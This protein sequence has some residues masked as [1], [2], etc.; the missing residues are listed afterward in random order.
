VLLMAVLAGGTLW[1][2]R[3]MHGQSARTQATFTVARKGSEILSYLSDQAESSDWKALSA[4]VLAL[5]CVENGLQ[6]V[7]VSRDGVTV[8]H[9]QTRGLDLAEPLGE[10]RDGL[11]QDI[12]IRRKLLDL[13]GEDVPVVVFNRQL[14]GE[15]GSPLEVEIAMR[16]ETVEREERAATM[17]VGSMFRLSLIAVIISFGTCAIL[18]VWMMRREVH[19]EQQRREEE[20]LAFAGAMANGIVHDFRNPMSAMQLDVQ[21]LNREVER[22]D[23]C[24]QERI[25]ELAGRVEKTV[26]RMDKV[27]QEFLYMSKPPSDER[28]A[29]DLSACV[30][31]CVSL[32]TP[33][34][35]QAKV[36]V[37][38]DMP[39]Q[40]VL[41]LAYLSG[42]QRALMNVIINAE[43]AS[44]EG[45]RVHIRILRAR[46]EATVDVID[47]GPGVPVSDRK[48]IFEMFTSNKPGGTG[49]GLFL[50]KTAIERCG[51]SIK[52]ADAGDGGTRFQ[53][54][55]PL[56][57]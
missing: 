17:A 12:T 15:D 52:V 2:L 46:L 34:L 48:R 19:R 22:G 4:Q 16:K 41:V 11:A 35:E 49:L 25:G 50:A 31:E 40:P 44:R 9:E 32:L 33:R 57:G 14:H 10:S 45:D 27:F 6:Y 26:E 51:G 28:D 18:V 42:L 8:F 43:Q 20:H 3:N 1:I 30:S 53:I 39:P 55:L 56:A 47:S 7:S 36:D 13:G 29:V 54:T 5:H 37:D 23:D 24:R 38:L 21:M